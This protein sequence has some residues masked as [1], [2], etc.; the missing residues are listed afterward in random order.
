MS[1]LINYDQPVRDLIDELSATGHVTHKKH[2][3]SSVTLHHNAGTGGHDRVL[4]TWQTRPASAHFNV[5]QRGTVAQYVKVNEYAWAT[6]N[7]EGNARSISIEMTN[8]GGHPN[9]P[10]NEETWRS[11]ARLVAWLHWKI[12]GTRPTRDTVKYHSDWKATACPGPHMKSRRNAVLRVAQ[13]AYDEFTG[14]SSPTTQPSRP[15]PRPSTSTPEI[16]KKH[17]RILEVPDDGKWGPN[18]DSRAIQMRNASWTYSG[19]PVKRKMAHDIKVVQRVIDTKDDGVWGPNSQEAL[20]GWIKEFQAH[21]GVKQD[22]VW[23]PKTD[24]KWMLA[25]RRHRNNY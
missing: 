10:V 17:Q 9:W 15:T 4:R 25:R 1:D 24:G 5:D 18:T 19:W 6:G 3:K 7:T 16:V 23:G 12:L 2:R 11:A 22:G 21:V 14:S 20:E 8:S 13:E